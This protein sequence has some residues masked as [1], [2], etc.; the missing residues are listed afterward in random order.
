MGTVVHTVLTVPYGGG[1]CCQA[2]DGSGETADHQR[3][4][5]RLRKGIGTDRFRPRHHKATP[6]TAGS[7]VSP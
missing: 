7:T 3:Y 5:V 2:E 1:Q 4:G 6:N